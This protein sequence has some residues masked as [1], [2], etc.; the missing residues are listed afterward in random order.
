M[1]PLKNTSIFLEVTQVYTCHNNINIYVKIL[2]YA[3]NQDLNNFKIRRKYIKLIN[4][5]Y[6]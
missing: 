1:Q 5:N 3:K 4:K 6:Y 2:N